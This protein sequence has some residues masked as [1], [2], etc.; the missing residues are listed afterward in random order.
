[1][2]SRTKRREFLGVTAAAAATGWAGASLF[3]AGA[4]ATPGPN[5]T[6]QLGVIGCG[7]R[8]QEICRNS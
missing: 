2:R 6:I 8:C 7:G 3:A 4:S 1:M 5:D